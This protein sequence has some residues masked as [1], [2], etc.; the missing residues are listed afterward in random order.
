MKRR[1]RLWA[2]GL[3]L[4]LAAGSLQMPAYAAQEPETQAAVE[5]EAAVL[6]ETEE[7]QIETELPV[8]VETETVPAETEAAEAVETEAAEAEAVPVYETEEAVLPVETEAAEEVLVEAEEEAEEPGDLFVEGPIV[9]FGDVPDVPME[10]PDVLFGQYVDLMFGQT[11]EEAVLLE[12][13]RQHPSER[14]SGYRL[15]VYNKL[16]SYIQQVASGSRT[17][18]V[19]TLSFSDLGLKTYTTAK[20]LGVKSLLNSRKTDYASGVED[21][22]VNSVSKQLDSTINFTTVID[23]LLAELPYDLYWFEKTEGWSY[24]GLSYRY[25]SSKKAIELS[26]TFKVTF[27]VAYDYQGSYT[28]VNTSKVNRAKTALNNAIKIVNNCAS[29]T[30]VNKLKTYK[31]KIC[32]LV[33]YDDYAAY[34]Y[35]DYG[36]SWQLVNVFDGDSSTDVVCEGYAKAFKLLCDRTSFYS[37][38]DCSIVGGEMDGEPHMWNIVS[39]PNGGNYIVDVTNCD[40]GSTGTDYLFLIVRNNAKT[41]GNYKSGYKVSAY[42]M[43]INYVYDS[44]ETIGIF[45]PYDLML[46]V[47]KYNANKT[48]FRDV[49][50]GSAYYYDPVYWAVGKGITNGYGGNYMFSP[51][52]NCTREQIVTFLWR[53]KGQPNPSYYTTFTDVKSS[54]W[55]Y[56]AIMWAASKGITTGLNDGTGRFG[57]GQPCTRE[58]AV[59]FLYRAAG[60]PSASSYSG[61]TDVSSGAYYAQA[62]TWAKKKGI[63]TGLN[64]GTGR[65]G[66]GQKCTRGMIVSFLYRYA[67]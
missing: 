27:Y 26:G 64:D 58:Q 57:V 56:K 19:F 44:R 29:Y 63:T 67:N 45:D 62:V 16:K 23:C 13:N 9:Q 48:W 35:K 2:L 47:G 66:V 52:V 28:S 25:N 32:S 49:L 39:M 6:P 22:F 50:D 15:K 17:S 40:S 41:G 33:E 18:T 51:N 61:F 59:T 4:L 11:T 20:D 54:D 30:D 55:Y 1:S 42:G 8:T 60:S 5:T 3:S 46:A 43:T 31:N 53:Q 12:A 36:D 38:I 14:F 65:F 21:K 34:G 7:A 24:E 37:D 10:E